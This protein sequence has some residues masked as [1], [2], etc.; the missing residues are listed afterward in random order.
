MITKF[1]ID[2]SGNSGDLIMSD[3]NI[4]FASQEYFTLACIGF[5]DKILENLETFIDDLKRKYKIQ[6]SELK[7]AKMKHIFG[8][9]I[10]FILELLKYIEEDSNFLVEIVDKKYI[11]ATNIVNCL[12]NPPYFQPEK[13]SEDEKMLHLI[14]AQWVY[15][16]V[17]NEFFI[18]FSN[19]SRNPSKN[20]LDK[21]FQDLL[22]LAK[23]ID[24]ELSKAVIMVIEESIDD[25]QIMQDKLKDNK[26]GREAYT[27]FL[28][29]PDYNK[30]GELI[31]MLPYISSFT[32]LHARLNHLYGVDLSSI[33]IIHDN[34]AHF[35]DILTEYH[36]NAKDDNGE[37]KRTFEMA[38]F[39]FTD[40]TSL[41]FH[42]DKNQIGLQIADIFAGLINKA[43]SYIIKNENYLKEN[44]YNILLQ[45]LT[46]FY[47]QK[48]IN[49]VLPRNHNIGIIFP[50]LEKNLQYNM[51]MSF[52]GIDKDKIDNQLIENLI[53]TRRETC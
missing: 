31:G 1:Y 52:K 6:N 41:E 14:L 48:S 44:E 11:I 8:H 3:K 24:T 46:S 23:E 53:N 13:T 37:S 32:N 36:K 47:Y 12:I 38:N 17:P 16:Y 7:F 40:T 5:E 9:K 30:R 25:Y 19:V 10:G 4:N 27:Y 50:I 22:S 45:I 28:P 2:E 39:N 43:T 15:E 18:E 33:T 35:N 21:L 34:Q 51:E 26:S 20:S 49:F 42:D 29:L